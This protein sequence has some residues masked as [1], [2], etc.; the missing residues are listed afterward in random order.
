M[1]VRIEV[2]EGELIVDALRRLRRLLKG[3]GGF[4]L[5][6]VRWHKKRHD[7]YQKPGVFRRRRRWVA[8]AKR[9]HGLETGPVDDVEIAFDLRPRDWWGWL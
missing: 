4:P 9:I 5:F 7:R 8:V 6:H 1:G 2:E 3:E